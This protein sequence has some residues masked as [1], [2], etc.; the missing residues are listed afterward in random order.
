MIFYNGYILYPHHRY[1]GYDLHTPTNPN[2]SV[3]FVNTLPT[4]AKFDVVLLSHVVEHL[5]DL[6]RLATIAQYLK[7]DGI[8]Y[9]E[10]P[11]P[12]H[13][14]DHPR[15]EF[16]YYIDRLHV[17]HFSLKAMIALAQR[18]GLAIKHY[19]Q[20]DLPYK[21]GKEYPAHYFYCQ[22][23]DKPTMGDAMRSYIAAEYK[24]PSPLAE[25]DANAPLL[26]YGFGDHFFRSRSTGGPLAGR[27]I[28]AVIDRRWEELQRSDYAK[29]YRF[30]NIEQALKAHA[31]VPIVIAVAWGAEQIADTIHALNPAV[32]TIIL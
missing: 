23:T 25:L 27:N 16:L 4:D 9:I 31:D 3:K 11:N 12:T 32:K 7:E 10:I 19:G 14:W 24:R 15:R 2:D 21:D 13:Y 1:L 6:N 5:V 20:H 8:L 26:V 22:K 30:L 17:N 29:T 18:M 28:V